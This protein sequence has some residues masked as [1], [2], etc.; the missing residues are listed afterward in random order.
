[1]FSQHIGQ[2]FHGNAQPLR[3]EFVLQSVAGEAAFQNAMDNLPVAVA[4]LNAISF[5]A[6]AVA[7]VAIFFGQVEIAAPAKLIGSAAGIEAAAGEPS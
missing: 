2:A 4:G 3:T 7:V 6:D 1:M 5:T